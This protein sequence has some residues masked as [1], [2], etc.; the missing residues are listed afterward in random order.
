MCREVIKGD[1]SQNH[2][3]LAVKMRRG[4]VIPTGG[5]KTGNGRIS[6]GRKGLNGKGKL[7]SGKSQKKTTSIDEEKIS[8]LKHE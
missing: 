7:S 6:Q 2:T 4:K 5:F 1:F 8:S 3:K